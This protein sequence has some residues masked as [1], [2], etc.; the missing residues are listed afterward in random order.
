LA[1]SAAT[2]TRASSPR[3][4]RA[5]PG[6]RQVTVGALRCDLDSDEGVAGGGYFGI[7]S[8]HIRI[9]E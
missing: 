7:D 8:K 6:Q 9:V 2:P 4:R 1:P 3:P 5:P